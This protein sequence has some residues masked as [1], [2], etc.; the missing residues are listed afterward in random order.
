MRNGNE[1]PPRKRKWKVLEQRIEHL[2]R[3]YRE[4]NRDGNAY[5]RAVCHCIGELV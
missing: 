1:P 2:K 5:W 3:Q 4:G